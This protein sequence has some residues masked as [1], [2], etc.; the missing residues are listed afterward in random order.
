MEPVRSNPNSKEFVEAPSQD[1]SVTPVM[2]EDAPPAKKK[3][4]EGRWYRVFF[5]PGSAA[6][7]ICAAALA[8]AIGMAVNAT[9]DSVPE[10]AIAIVGIPGTLWL[11]ALQA[12]G[13]L[14]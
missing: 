13:E 10:A 2:P 8:I 12:V 4:G 14:L 1:I 11:R 6:Q 9:V 5:E 3:I 7:I